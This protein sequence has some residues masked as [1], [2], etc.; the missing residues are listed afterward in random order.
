MLDEDLISLKIP[1]Y[2]ITMLFGLISGAEKS[3]QV[4]MRQ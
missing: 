3:S 2:R 1:P 4:I